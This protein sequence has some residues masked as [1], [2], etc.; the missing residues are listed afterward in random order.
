MRFDNVNFDG[1]KP[2]RAGGQQRRLSVRARVSAFNI[3]TRVKSASGVW[4]VATIAMG[5]KVIKC[6]Y[7]LNVL[8][9]TCN[10][11]CYLAR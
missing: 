11:S 7:P 8:K 4:V 2:N 6:P 10:H 9:Y 5:G 3:T 1:L